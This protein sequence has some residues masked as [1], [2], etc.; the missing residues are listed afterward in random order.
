MPGFSQGDQLTM[1]RLLR[2]HRGKLPSYLF[3]DISSKKREKLARMLVLL[4]MAVILKHAGPSAMQPDF[5]ARAK[6]DKLKVYFPAQWRAD[7]PL[8][9]WEI[10]E[11]K[12]A[13]EK[14]GVKVRL[15]KDTD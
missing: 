10:S 1:S 2:G 12:S 8:T 13:F 3:E 11:S 4:R 9:I 15:A 7:Y 14:L 5:S 6:G